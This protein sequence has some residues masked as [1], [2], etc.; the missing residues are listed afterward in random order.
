MKA[1]VER[2]VWEW[3][4]TTGTDLY[5][6]CGTRVWHSAYPTIEDW[7]ATSAGVVFFVTNATNDTN[8]QTDDV[9]IDFRCHGA[10]RTYTAAQ[11]CARALYS[12]LQAMGGTTTT[13]TIHRAFRQSQQNLTDPDT[14]WPFV[15]CRYNLIVE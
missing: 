12:R 13:G 9:T 11:A 10:D 3:L 7:N 4:T 14:G 2:I 8:G 6:L 15:L 5:T 1:N